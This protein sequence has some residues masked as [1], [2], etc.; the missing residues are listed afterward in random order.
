M[1]AVPFDAASISLEEE[2][3]VSGMGRPKLQGVPE[4]SKASNADE[5][6]ID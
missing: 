3:G 1:S 4:V 2:E 6:G 5:L